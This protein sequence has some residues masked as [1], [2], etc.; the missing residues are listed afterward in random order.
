[1]LLSCFATTV[2]AQQEASTVIEWNG[3]NKSFTMRL[4]SLITLSYKATEQGTLYIYSDNQSMYD[5]VPVSIWGGLYADGTYNTDFPLEDAGP[6][7]NGL[8]VYGKIKV[9]PGDEVR[10]T[11]STPAE[12]GGVMT[13][14]TLKSLFFKEDFGG[15]TWENPIELTQDATVAVP[16]YKNYDVDYLDE[17]SNATFCRF[18]PPTDGVAS[19]LTEDY[20]IYYIKEEAYG[21]EKLKAVPQDVATNDHEFVVEKGKAYLVLIPNNRPTNITFTM[22]SDR[23]GGNCKAPIELETFPATLDLVKGDNFFRMNLDGLG[24]SYIMELAAAAGWKGTITYMDNCDYESEELQPATIDG[25]G[26]SYILNLSPQ[27]MG[28]ELIMNI[29][30]TDVDA[31]KGAVTLKLREPAAGECMDKAIAIQAGENP[32][33]GPARDYWFVYTASQD[34]ELSVA[35]TGTLKHMLY[36]H[37][38]GNIINE[39][40]DALPIYAMLT[41]HGHVIGKTRGFFDFRNPAVCEHVFGIFERLYRKG[42]RFIK[43]DYNQNIGIG[44]DGACGQASPEELRRNQEAFM[45]LID[46]VHEAFPDLVIENCSSGC[47]RADHASERHFY[48]QSVSDQEYY[49]R[50]P[51]VV[52]GLMACMPPERVGIWGYPYPVPIDLRESFAPSAEFTAR[53]ADGHNTVFNMVQTMLG[54]MYLSGH[55]DCADGENL[56]LMK[57]AIELYK[58]NR[59]LLAKAYPVY[60]TGLTRMADKGILSLGMCEPQ[61]GTLLVAVWKTGEQ[62]YA[63]IDLGKYVGKRAQIAAMYPARTKDT[64]TLKGSTLC[65]DFPDCDSAVWVK[66]L[67]DE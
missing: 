32:F 23:I 8:G 45:A 21:S 67:S 44:V 36:S 35:T 34:A 3:K 49:E 38:G 58:Q 26:A 63:E 18:T 56:A 15:D 61:S 66:M 54:C 39:Y 22:S 57:E 31:A 6:Y 20:L 24:E 17:F 64:V 1:M 7:G 9:W 59:D 37:G 2:H 48:M 12:A 29:N 41:R 43:N 53:F 16:V 33:S 60:P 25:T 4:D 55:I 42:I 47:M 14:F 62:T 40:N 28:H 5:N 27:F 50:M 19:I 46:R 13:R 65:V 51:S 52:Q 10:F 11:L 30:V